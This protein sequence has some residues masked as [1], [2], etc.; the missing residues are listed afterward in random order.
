MP[1]KKS[2]ITIQDVADAAGV[3]VSTVS[4]VLNG[5][6]DVSEETKENIQR[7]IEE[8]GYTS[9]LAA[10]SMR[11][12]SNNVIGVL[13]VDVSDPFSIEVVRGIGEAI[14]DYRYDLLI[15]SSGRPQTRSEA[16]WERNQVRTLN[17]SITDGMIV[18]TPVA[19]DLPSN[20]PLVVIDP[21]LIDSAGGYVISTNREG[22]L[23]GMEHLLSLGHRRI[24]FVGGLAELLSSRERR[25]GYEDA[26]RLAGIPVDPLLI[27]SGDYTEVQGRRCAEELLSLSQRPTAIFAAND[28]SALGVLDALR[29][30]GLSVPDDISLLGFDNIPESAIIQ[31]ALTTV[32]QP[33]R[34][35]GA[36]ATKMLMHLLRKEPV[37]ERVC[38]TLTRLV[39]RQSTGP[40]RE[41]T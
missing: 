13:M 11:S 8:L 28:R 14:H 23:S 18:V 31:P 29:G 22:A 3:S 16:L 32:E 4:R 34:E 41:V 35:M 12:H 36:T 6:D 15:Y 17:G 37:A 7:I 40:V 24:G 33:L 30:A 21:A 39:I 25:Q 27:R 5:K 20:H 9:S 19:R 1:R 38:R 26:L 2:A 10:R